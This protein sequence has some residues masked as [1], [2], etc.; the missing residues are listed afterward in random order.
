MYL[1]DHIIE[2]AHLA[3]KEKMTNHPVMSIFPILEQ[4][5]EGC[6]R[7]L[8]D[9]NAIHTAVELTLGRPKVL[10][11]AMNHLRI[12]YTKLWVEWLES[13]RQKLRDT[14]GIVEKES[15]VLRP[16]PTRLG[17]L[18][19]VD[20]SGRK[21]VVTWG[22]TNNFVEDNE[23]PN[24]CPISAYFD[25][26]GNFSQ[27]TQRTNFL[28]ANLAQ[29]WK[30]N[31]IQTEALLSIWETSQHQPSDW[32]SRFLTNTKSYD[33]SIR[34]QHFY[35]DI[36]GEYIMIWAC[37]M[38]LTSSRKILDYEEV[39]LSKLNKARISKDQ[40]PKLDHTRISLHIN[41]EVYVH[42]KGVPLG[43]ERKSP[44]I[45]MVSSYLGR[46]GNKH[47]IV[48]PYWRGKGEVIS[49]HVHVKV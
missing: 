39:N 5:L 28:R 43:F 1:M 35:A 3:R 36:Y 13:G 12:P 38:L 9:D 46:R 4:K 7:F 32:G 24:I 20:E 49:R 8:F 18:M 19:E 6:P 37:M 15:L 22:W 11:E 10:R 25:L 48:Q 14:F 33:D 23:P 42:Q 47:W 34:V 45:H 44:R 31:P 2:S 30:E 17:F 40:P 41:K 26:D 21:G 29:M 16:L 27:L